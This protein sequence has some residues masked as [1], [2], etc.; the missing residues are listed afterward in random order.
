MCQDRE[1]GLYYN[2]FRDYDPGSGRYTEFDP[3]GLS[4]GMNGY[5]YVGGNP[6]SRIDP[7]GLAGLLPKNFGKG[8]SPGP[9][10]DPIKETRAKNE[11]NENAPDAIDSILCS[12]G[13]KSC[14]PDEAFV[15]LK[16]ECTR[17]CGGEKYTIDYT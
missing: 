8:N 5:A 7:Y 15:C 12:I 4:G 17:M 2:Y 11:S 3:I 13:L 6:I 1:T 14:I 10:P 9:L 16:A